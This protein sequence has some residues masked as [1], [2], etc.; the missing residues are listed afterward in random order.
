VAKGQESD[1]AVRAKVSL[2]DP[3]TLAILWT[4]DPALVA[5][6]LGTAITIGD[7]VPMAESLG[8][9][10][11]LREVAATG[12]SRNLKVD[13]VSTSKGAVAIVISLYRLPDGRLMVVSENAWQ[14]GRKD[15]RSSRPG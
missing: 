10:A 5:R 13:L 6:E 11:A 1:T 7:V 9:P 8:V 15:G 12:V 2:V 14:M 4:N 3:D